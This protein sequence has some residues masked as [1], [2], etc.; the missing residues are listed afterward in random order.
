LTS[1][2]VEKILPKTVEELEQ[3][4][5]VST[6]ALPGLANMPLLEESVDLDKAES[7][8]LKEKLISLVDMSPG[9][10]AQIIADWIVQ[11]DLAAQGKKQRRK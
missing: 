6:N 11:A 10:A 4:E 5:D 2:K 1:T 8:M 9:K 7:E 3:L